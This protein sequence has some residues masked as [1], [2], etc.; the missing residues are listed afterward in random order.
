MLSPENYRCAPPCPA[1]FFFFFFFLRQ[2]FALVAQAGV[3]WRDLGSLQPPP[4][5]FKGFS[6]LS[7]L[8]SWDYR[9]PPPRPANFCIFSRDGV[10]PSWPATVPGLQFVFKS[11]Y[12]VQRPKIFLL[13]IDNRFAAVFL[14]AKTVPGTQKQPRI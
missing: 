3:Q 10:S 13:Q 11:S 5:K 6:C 1:N 14:T 7:R 8:C 9:R 4:P 2:S 12:N